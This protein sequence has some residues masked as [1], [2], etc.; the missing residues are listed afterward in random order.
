MTILVLVI[1]DFPCGNKGVDDQDKPGHDGG[2]AIGR[3]G[4]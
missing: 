4:S 3:V 2:R 1:H